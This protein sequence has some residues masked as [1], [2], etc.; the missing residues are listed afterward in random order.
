MIQSLPGAKGGSSNQLQQAKAEVVALEVG[1][2]EEDGKLVPTLQQVILSQV[3]CCGLGPQLHL[4]WGHQQKLQF[5]LS[6]GAG[7]LG[8]LHHRSHG[9]EHKG[10]L[11]FGRHLTREHGVPL[12]WGGVFIS[13]I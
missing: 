7:C 4:S 5:A 12:P 11:L 9:W 8:K 13:T 2:L 6:L 1:A 3:T 10:C